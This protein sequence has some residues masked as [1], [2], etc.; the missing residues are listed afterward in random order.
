VL[1]RQASGETEPL[2][3]EEVLLSMAAYLHRGLGADVLLDLLPV[4]AK[5]ENRTEIQSFRQACS[6]T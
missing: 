3:L 5:P 2:D 1:R 6:E 4:A